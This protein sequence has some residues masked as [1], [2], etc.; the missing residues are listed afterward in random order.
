MAK[1]VEVIKE[2]PS[3]RN[4]R[5]KDTRNGKIMSRLEFVK[6]I[7]GGNYPDYYVREINDLTTPVSKPDGKKS[8]NLD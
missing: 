2:S 8:N 7:Q 3:G 1:T 6:Q 5:F 4:Q